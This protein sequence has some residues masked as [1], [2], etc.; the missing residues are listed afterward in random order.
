[1]QFILRRTQRRRLHHKCDRH[2]HYGTP[3]TAQNKRTSRWPRNCTLE[4]VMKWPIVFLVFAAGIGAARED[5]T[6]PVSQNVNARYTVESVQLASPPL[7]RI[8]RSLRSEIDA[9][10]G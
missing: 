10:V 5:R 2:S 3:V 8:S 9:L 6:E 4:G 1:M 7:K